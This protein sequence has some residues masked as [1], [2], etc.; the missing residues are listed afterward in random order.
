L[1]RCS[2]EEDAVGLDGAEAA[3]DDARP[4]NFACG[5]GVR[6]EDPLADGMGSGLQRDL[7]GLGCEAIGLR[8]VEAGSTD[9]CDDAGPRECERGA[10]RF[11]RLRSEKLRKM[12][13]KRVHG[14]AERARGE[15]AFVTPIE[16]ARA[17]QG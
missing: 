8:K 4:T 10:C 15:A 11:E 14:D 6:E 16:L 5:L 13:K 7:D 1:R 9:A 12:V 2:G 3:G 17:E